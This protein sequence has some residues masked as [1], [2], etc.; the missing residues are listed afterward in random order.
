MCGEITDLPKLSSVQ[1]EKIENTLC[2]L[3]AKGCLPEDIA[4]VN[5]ALAKAMLTLN[6]LSA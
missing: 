3:A 2:E 5:F 4:L 6:L 1:S